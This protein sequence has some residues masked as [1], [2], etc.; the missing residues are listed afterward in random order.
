[1]QRQLHHAI[2]LRWLLGLLLC[3]ATLA[4]ANPQKVSFP[5]SRSES[6]SPD[7]HYSVRNFDDENQEPAHT[8]SLIDTK[9]R[10]AIKIYSY[11]RHVDVLWSPSSDALVINDYEGSDVS[12]PVLFVAP[13]KGQPVDLSEKLIEFF[14]VH[15]EP[16]SA[17]KNHHMYFSAQRWLSHDE[18]LCRID[19]YGQVDPNGF[20]SNYIYKL[21]EGFRVNSKKAGGAAE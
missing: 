2:H 16:K 3:V 15:G 12:H 4:K 6:K 11:G 18:I 8:L 1:M 21:G 7:G 5:G 20:T 17:T 14:R 10:S 9:T 13:W 19:S